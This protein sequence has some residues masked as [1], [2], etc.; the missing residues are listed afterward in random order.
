MKPTSMVV[1]AALLSAGAVLVHAQ[2]AATTTNL[3]TDA[4]GNPM[5]R[6]IK[7]GH[8]SNYDEA[9]VGTYTLPDPLVSSDRA[10]VRDAKAWLT[11]RRPEIIRLYET[12]I[13]GR[14]PANAPRV[15]WRVADTDAHARDGADVLKRITGTIGSAPGAT[16]I[17]QWNGTKWLLQPGA[18]PPKAMNSALTGVSCV[19]ATR[20]LAVG[21]YLTHKFGNPAAGYSQHR[22]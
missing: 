5:R 9:N 18:D 21:T 4:N 3:G 15:T 1:T 19:E 2:Q 20:C 22:S 6:A 14:I 10:P 16:L 7:T 11:R 8:I 13:F 12:E 17:E